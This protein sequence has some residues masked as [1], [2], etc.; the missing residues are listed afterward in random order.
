MMERLS[1][2]LPCKIAAAIVVALLPLTNA[3][4]EPFAAADTA[5]LGTTGGTTATRTSEDS[6][7]AIGHTDGLLLDQLRPRHGGSLTVTS[8]AFNDGADIPFENTQYRGNVFPGLRWTPGPSATRSYVVVMQG[9]SLKGSLTSIH[10]T[11]YNIPAA[12]T[13]L[14]AGMTAPPPGASYGPNVHGLNQAYAGPHSHTPARQRYHL[15][16]FA[17][18]ARLQAAPDLSFEAL[19]AVMRGHVLAS[20]ELV[21]WAARDPR[22]GGS[23]GAVA[24]AQHGG[25]S[26]SES[27]APS[28]AAT[29]EAMPK[30]LP[31]ANGPPLLAALEAAKAAEQTCAGKGAKVSVL[32]ADSVG[33]PVVLLS[34]DGAG[35]RSQLIT[36]TKVAI[37]VR[38]KRPSGDVAAKAETDPELKAEAA[39]DPNIGVL[40]GGGFPVMRGDAMVGVVAVSGGSLSGNLGLDEECA[41]VAVKRLEGR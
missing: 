29:I 25:A 13:E 12:L 15:Q 26:A 33:E 39:A 10:L 40:R 14:E 20:G 1:Q 24:P 37:V 36:R 5:R 34:G 6:G 4:V 31:R 41:K 8:Q 30:N 23:E 32:V 7:S 3:A 2:R 27:P 17:L 38:Y 35:V 21:G 11:L 9:E 22:A 19:E 18:D 28:L 16:V